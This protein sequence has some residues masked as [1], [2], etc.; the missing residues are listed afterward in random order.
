[1]IPAL[2][3][4][5]KKLVTT[6]STYVLLGIALALILFVTFYVEGW[7]ANAETL[8]DPLFLNREPLSAIS[9]VT[10]LMTMIGILLMTHEYRYNMITYS[11]TSSNSRSKVLLAKLLVVSA[12]A[13][14][15]ATVVWA[16]APLVTLLGVNA[17]GLELVPQQFY[18][19]DLWWRCAFFAWGF[20][21]FGLLLA[22]LIRN[23]I[24]TIVFL[25]I[26]P[27]T[28][29]GILSILLKENSVYLPFSSLANVIGQS[30]GQ[31]VVTPAAS[32]WLFTLYMIG[33]WAVA[34]YL[35][36]RRD[37]N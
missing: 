29:E 14:I 3:A 36:L 35:F 22:V 37:A 18:Y 33:G 34:W 19:W 31:A 1:M 23:Q 25:L 4:E 32:A 2:K 10:I 24:G 26:V 6:R 30:G 15:F 20:A 9:V 11:L 13:I 17:H 21:I 16:L 12:F 8:Q 28:I 27:N 5:F 7:R